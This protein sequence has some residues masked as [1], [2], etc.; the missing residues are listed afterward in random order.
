VGS[1]L[2]RPRLE[3]P[4]GKGGAG[5]E[6]AGGEGVGGAGGEGVGGEGAGGAG[7]EG[8]G[9]GAGGAGGE[10]VGGEGAGGEGVGGGGGEGVGGEGVGGEGVRCSPRAPC[11]WSSLVLLV[12]PKI[13][14]SKSIS[15]TGQRK[16]RGCHTSSI[17][18]APRH[19]LLTISMAMGLLTFAI[20]VLCLP[21]FIIPIVPTAVVLM[22]IWFVFSS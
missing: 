5:G 3:G 13:S 6:G 1:A 14:I 17:L 22:Q 11:C 10:G 21:R 9:E 8:V 16:D 20:V 7:G 4:E 15:R 2:G 19:T 12:L 18:I